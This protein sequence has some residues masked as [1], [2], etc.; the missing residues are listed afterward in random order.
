MLQSRT[1]EELPV[2]SGAQPVTT[3]SNLKGAGMKKRTDVPKEHQEG[4]E[5]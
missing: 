1:L 2:E 4:G 3:F 5:D